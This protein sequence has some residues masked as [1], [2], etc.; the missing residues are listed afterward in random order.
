MGGLI[1]KVEVRVIETGDDIAAAE[2]D[3]QWLEEIA[4][5]MGDDLLRFLRSRLPYD[6]DAE[7]LAQ[8]VYLRLLRV[9]DRE[10]IENQRAYILR[11]AANIANEWR[12]LA[13]NRLGHSSEALATLVD[14]ADPAREAMV[15]RQMQSLEAA[16]LTLSPK[17]RAVLLMHR[18]DRYTYVEIAA[19]MQMSVSMVKKY[20][21]KGLSVCQECLMH[22]TGREART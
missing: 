1:L 13:R 16:L 8:E 22:E 10:R 18:R 6:S 11:V 4:Q 21:V 9:K 3:R 17:C 14:P 12:L 20:L 19:E 5:S 2:G 15:E 7:D